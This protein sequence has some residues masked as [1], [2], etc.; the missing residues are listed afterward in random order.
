MVKRMTGDGFEL[1][2]Q[3][4]FLS[5]ARM[6]LRLSERG[7]HPLRQV[8]YVSSNAH[9][10]GHLPAIFPLSFWARYARSK[11]RATTF[12]HAVRPLFPGSVISVISPGN[13][14]TA[15]HRHKHWLVRRLRD[16]LGGAQLADAAA[17]DLL[18]AAFSSG[19]PEAYWNRGK[20]AAPSERCSA[21]ALRLVAWADGTAGLPMGRQTNQA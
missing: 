18:E 20:I 6:F 11:L 1:H 2:H 14:E 17:G 21:R 9:K 15:V 16:V 10:M 12:F 8:V 19:K 3:V 4:N 13:V 5:A 7:G